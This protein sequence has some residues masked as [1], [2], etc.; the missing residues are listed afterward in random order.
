M[1]PRSLVFLN[2][3]VIGD[4]GVIPDGMVTVTGGRITYAGPRRDDRTPPGAERVDARGL[5]IGCPLWQAVRMASL[6]PAE[7]IGV[8][9]ELGSLAPEKWAADVVLFDENV[10]V[11]AVYVGGRRLRFE[12]AAE[13]SRG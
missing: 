11:R 4:S 3:A 10:E 13:G 2:G 5:Y 1:I 7:I 8:A 9:D 6:T 12:A